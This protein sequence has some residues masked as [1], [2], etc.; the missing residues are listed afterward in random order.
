[1]S[2]LMANLAESHRL[3]SKWVVRYLKG[4]QKVGLTYNMSQGVRQE[5]SRYID[6]D[7]ASDIDKKITNKTYLY[8]ICIVIW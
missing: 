4:T 7:F 3:T 1:M 6:L 5:I 8:L 2:R